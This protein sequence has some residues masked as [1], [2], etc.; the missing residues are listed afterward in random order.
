MAGASQ[1]SLPLISSDLNLTIVSD[2]I[3]LLSLVY[4]GYATAAFWIS[5][6]TR[7]IYG[8]RD[9]VPDVTV[10]IP[11][12]NEESQ[13]GGLLESLAVVDY[14]ADRLQIIVMNDQS[15]DR[16]G[17]IARGFA[18]RFACR[19]EVRD[20]V[21]LP[22]DR[23]TAKTRA[24]AQGLDHAKCEIVLM[25]DADCVVPPTWVRSMTSYFTSD[26]GMVCGMTVP[27]PG[28]NG[29]E[30]LTRYETLDWLFLLGA[31][32]GLA[33][34]GKP[35][36][37]IG[38]NYSVRKSTYDQIGTYQ[39]LSYTSPYDDLAL[40][41]AV[42]ESGMRVVSPTDAGVLLHT[43]PLN[44]LRE[45]A[46]QRQRWLRGMP[47]TGFLGN[48]VILF[49]ILAHVCLPIW[50]ILCG[51]W[52]LIPYSILALA[53]AFVILPMLRSYR[54]DGLRSRLPFYPAFAACY[55]LIMVALVI[56]RRKIPWKERQV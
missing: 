39:A 38:N 34:L 8:H 24:L 18:D 43:K 2:L 53:D 47:R 11:A 10:V 49:G 35:K 13:I 55:G 42:A 40:L 14:P 33:G 44:S 37:L 3:P 29:T 17:E 7:R 56:L 12:R 25:T 46:V 4:A 51:I 20:V 9:D 23:L 27:E 22:G 6:G 54:I 28:R 30:T 5:R 1:L 45:L 32:G 31:S 36:G 41:N 19:F 52:A 15:T 50:F 26:V 16:T 21:D 48:A